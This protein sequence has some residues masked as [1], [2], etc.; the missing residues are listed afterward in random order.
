MAKYDDPHR[1]NRRREKEALR[2]EARC[3]EQNKPKPVEKLK[4]GNVTIT[5]GLN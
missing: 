4:I 2:N 3:Y 1:R 5:F